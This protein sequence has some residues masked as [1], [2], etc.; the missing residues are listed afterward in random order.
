MLEK[1]IEAK[2]VSAVKAQGGKSLKFVS[3]GNVGV[4]DRIVIL[5]GGRIG[6][7][8]AKQKGKKPTKHQQL[9]IQRL[10]DLGCFVTVLDDVADI[11]TLL[12][13]IRKGATS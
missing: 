5:P 6:F 2:L 8:E 1:E 7:V 11:P 3:P 12:D 4:P 13:D 9:Q 10:K